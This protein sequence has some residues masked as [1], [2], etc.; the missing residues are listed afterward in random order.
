MENDKNFHK[1]EICNI[2]VDLILK[3]K[4]LSDIGEGIANEAKKK[5]P[6]LQDED[7]I[8][9][10][11]AMRLGDSMIDQGKPFKTNPKREPSES[12]WS[13][14]YMGYGEI[15]SVDDFLKAVFSEEE[16]KVFVSN[17]KQDTNKRIEEYIDQYL[18]FHL[19][20]ARETIKEIH[21][22]LGAMAEESG[23][24]L[25]GEI[26]LLHKDLKGK[27]TEYIIPQ[28]KTTAGKVIAILLC[29][30]IRRLAKDRIVQPIRVILLNIHTWESLGDLEAGIKVCDDITSTSR[31]IRLYCL[32]KK[33]SLLQRKGLYV[34]AD[35][36]SGEVVYLK[37]DDADDV[38]SE[39]TV[40][41]NAIM[42]E[43]AMGNYQLAATLSDELTTI[44]ASLFGYDKLKDPSSYL[45]KNFLE[46]KNAYMIYE[47]MGHSYDKL[48]RHDDAIASF[49]QAIKVSPERS[50]LYMRIADTKANIARAKLQAE[51]VESGMELYREA[52][53]A[54]TLYL[55]DHRQEASAQALSICGFICVVLRK[56]NEARKWS[57]MS[58]EKNPHLLESISNMGLISEIEGNLEEAETWYKKALKISPGHPVIINNIK[59]VSEG[60]TVLNP[61]KKKRN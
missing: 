37:E 40:Y 16:A 47:H 58:M 52:Y 41:S 45:A 9:V 28:G 29:H 53:N 26:S 12:Q 2:G 10:D 5:F 21:S 35:R 57:K 42:N 46:D 48:S 34:E 17:L 22:R 7:I 14:R 51:D 19:T 38:L 44:G 3:V 6:K 59:R 23:F 43:T 24:R 55:K 18:S 30:E 13:V 20:E 11:C 50:D 4:Y 8:C 49:M 1:C 54:A 60:N 36:L 56:C 32:L 31:A 33:R 15:K 27:K 39:V 25:S 61:P